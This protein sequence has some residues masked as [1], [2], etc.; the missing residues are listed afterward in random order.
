MKNS[1]IFFLI[2]YIFIISTQSLSQETTPDTTPKEQKI[3]DELT[4]ITLPEL[5]EE[6]ELAVSKKD[7]TVLADLDIDSAEVIKEERTTPNEG[8]PYFTFSGGLA[9]FQG[10]IGILKYFIPEWWG[11]LTIDLVG[12]PSIPV[13]NYYEATE[14][15]KPYVAFKIIT[16]WAF[17][18]YRKF[19]MSLIVQVQFAFI[20][21]DDMPIL[22]SLGMRFIIDFL[23]LDIGV[24]Y[25]FVAGGVDDPIFTG[26]Y[27]VVSIGFRF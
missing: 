14:F 23:Y 2:I 3:Q 5:P 21:S 27:P 9:P 4:N 1:K 26:W 15:Y 8:N 25:A 20:S 17:Y 16:G 11:Q 19:E 7:D 22:P 13:P 12:L 24:A 18:S 6:S 10:S